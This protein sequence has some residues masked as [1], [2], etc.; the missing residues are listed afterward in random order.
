MAINTDSK[1]IKEILERGIEQVINKNNLLKKLKAGKKLRI[2]LG[3]D[4]TG[5]KMHIGRAIQLWKLRAF[6]DLGGG[7]K[8][9]MHLT[10]KP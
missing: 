6:Q 1:K 10:S 5:P 4:P 7:E 8:L 9:E 2:K 3:V